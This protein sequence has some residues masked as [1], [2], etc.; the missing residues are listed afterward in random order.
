MNELLYNEQNAL[1]A[2][3]RLWSSIKTRCTNRARADYPSYGGRGIRVSHEFS[4][5]FL[6]F[7]GYASGLPN[8]ENRESLRLT[9]DRIDNNRSYER[10]NLRWATRKEQSHN[11]RPKA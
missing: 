1:C 11:R 3:S 7:Y 5:D 8:Y 9:L 2:P 4:D 6:A 10:G